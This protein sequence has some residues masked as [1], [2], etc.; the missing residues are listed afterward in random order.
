MHTGITP[1]YLCFLRIKSR[2]ARTYAARHVRHRRTE[3]WCTLAARHVRHRRIELWCTLEIL[4]S[5][6]QS[7]RNT[8]HWCTLKKNQ[9]TS[10]AHGGASHSNSR[11]PLRDNLLLAS[12]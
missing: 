4:K 7:L 11:M 8:E 5:I 12:V 1:L 9:I 2:H 6:N 3:L 10:I